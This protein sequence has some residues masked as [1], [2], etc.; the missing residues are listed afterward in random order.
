MLY[1]MRISDE[2]VKAMKERF[3][4]GTRIVLDRMGY[5]PDPIE[6]GETGTV[7]GVDDIGTVHVDWDSGRRLGLIPGHDTFRVVGETEKTIERGER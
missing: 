2:A 5:D 3:P 6:C 7:T 4:A 1:Y